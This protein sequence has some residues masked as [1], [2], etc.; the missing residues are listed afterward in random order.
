LNF[1]FV[2]K[3]SV[4]YSDARHSA[5]AHKRTTTK[6]FSGLT[7]ILIFGFLHHIKNGA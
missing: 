7:P 6:F 4:N 3:I 1:V 2:L 5:L